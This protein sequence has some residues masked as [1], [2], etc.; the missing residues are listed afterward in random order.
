[1][2]RVIRRSVAKAERLRH[3]AAHSTNRRSMPRQAGERAAT[4]PQACPYHSIPMSQ[5]I[6]ESGGRY[7]RPDI[8]RSSSSQS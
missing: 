1:M 6:T 3:P 4:K 7:S 5:A 8:L 2:S